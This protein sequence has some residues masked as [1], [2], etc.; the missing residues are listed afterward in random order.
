MSYRFAILWLK[1]FRDSPEKVCDLYADDFLFEGLDAGQW[2]CHRQGRPVPRIRALAD[3]G[4]RR[5][6]R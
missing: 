2:D 5:R 3:Q 1:A 6:Q 4:H